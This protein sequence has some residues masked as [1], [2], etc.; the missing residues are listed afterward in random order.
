MFSL[1]SFIFNQILYIFSLILFAFSPILY[2][3]SSYLYSVRSYIYSVLYYFYSV[4]SYIF[5][6]SSYLYS[7]T[8]FIYSVSSY[9]IQ[10]FFCIQSQ[11][12][13]GRTSYRK[14]CHAADLEIIKL[15]KENVKYKKTKI[16]KIEY[17]IVIRI[18]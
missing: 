15:N 6:V 10:S 1:N 4:T 16:Q 12:P 18:L 2:S 11:V 5:S 7:V 17:W 8:S 3:I 9:F 14:Y 13:C